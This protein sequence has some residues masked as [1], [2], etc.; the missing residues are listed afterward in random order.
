[1]SRK[2]AGITRSKTA[3]K[4]P[5]SADEGTVRVPA[6][7]EGKRGEQGYLGYLLRQAHAAVRLTM[8][9]TLADLGVT[10]PQFAVLTMLNAYPG[11]SGADVARLTFL[12]PQTVGVIIRNLERDGAIEMTP[13]PVHGRIQQWML[14]SRGATLLK[15]C[16]ERVIALE[17]RLAGGLDAKTEASIRRWLA[18][19]AADLQEG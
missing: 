14:T 11:L 5:M 8:E 16:R 3:R 6:P 13:H 12:T 19:I 10:S 2:S 15:A 7:G 18:G 4:T 9:R 1:M 17:K